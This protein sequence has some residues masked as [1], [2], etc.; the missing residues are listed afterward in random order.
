MPSLASIE[1]FLKGRLFSSIFNLIS[2]SKRLFRVLD[3]LNNLFR[4]FNAG[5]Y[6]HPA[7][8]I[9]PKNMGSPNGFENVVGI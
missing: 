2:A 4:V 1:C 5:A 3:E 9:H 7:G 8:H 6:L